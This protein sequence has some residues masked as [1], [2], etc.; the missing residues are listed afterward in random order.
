MFL[1]FSDNMKLGGTT[2]T[3]HNRLRIN[4]FNRLKDQANMNK[5]KFNRHKCKNFYLGT[6]K[7][8]G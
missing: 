4:N 1:I 8:I 6:Q 7:S 2:Y 5:M 3:E